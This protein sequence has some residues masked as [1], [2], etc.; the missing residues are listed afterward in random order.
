M[1]GHRSIEAYLQPMFARSYLVIRFSGP[2]RHQKNIGSAQHGEFLVDLSSIEGTVTLEV[3][4][5]NG[6]LIISSQVIKS[7][8]SFNL[9]DFNEGIY[10]L[11]IITLDAVYGQRLVLR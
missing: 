9:S 7:D 5:A 2:F 11:R 4:G 10:Q 8:R 6:Q 3:F 1:F